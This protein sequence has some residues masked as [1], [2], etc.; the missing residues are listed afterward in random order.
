MACGQT[1]SGGSI[2]FQSGYFGT[3][4]S[5]RHSGFSRGFT[6]CAHAATA[7][8]I[9]KYP[10]AH[11]NPGNLVIEMY[12]P[13]DTSYAMPPIDQAPETITITLPLRSGQASA[14]DMECT[15]FLTEADISMPFDE[16]MMLTATLELSGTPTFTA[17]VNA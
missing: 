10:H 5:I 13:D 17:A 3:I 9:T 6:E 11:I 8:F 16:A 4:R 15:G 7:G 14:A 1:F 2:T 12:L